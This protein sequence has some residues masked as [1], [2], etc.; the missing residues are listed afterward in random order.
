MTYYLHTILS[1]LFRN[2]QET[3]QDSIHMQSRLHQDT[4]RILSRQ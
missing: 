2:Y 4:I 1:I 3:Y